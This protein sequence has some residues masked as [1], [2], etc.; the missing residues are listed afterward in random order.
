MMNK[1]IGT[2][3]QYKIK[4]SFHAMQRAKERKVDLLKIVS[5]I[6]SFGTEKLEEYA[7]KKV[8]VMIKD[9]RE[10]ISIIFAVA[11]SKITVITVVH[12]TDVYDR[13]YPDTIVKEI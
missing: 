10:N 12:D 13:N 8:D 5:T 11:K 1:V 6:T 3:G 2:A 7:T 9:S 4:M